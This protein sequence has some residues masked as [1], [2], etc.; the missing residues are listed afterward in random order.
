MFWC[1]FLSSDLCSV[2]GLWISR[3]VV[4]VSALS[5]LRPESSS[6]RIS[7][8]PSCAISPVG[9]SVRVLR[10]CALGGLFRCALWL[11]L[12]KGEEVRFL[13]IGVLG[14]IWPVH[15]NW[16]CAAF[17]Y[18]DFAILVCPELWIDIVSLTTSSVLRGTAGRLVL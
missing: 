11:N 1:F 10:T 9:C 16:S 7:S 17:L 6:L 15:F 14:G 5:V 8:V 2:L 12:V 13:V 3:G 4:L 18:L